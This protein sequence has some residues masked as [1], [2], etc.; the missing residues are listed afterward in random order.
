MFEPP[1][2]TTDFDH[3]ADA[4]TLAGQTAPDPEP[5]TDDGPWESLELQELKLQELRLKARRAE[6]ERRHTAPTVIDST[7]T[8]VAAAEPPEPVWPHQLIEVQDK[9][10][11]VKQPPAAAIRYLGVFGFG[12]HGVTRGDFQDFMHRHVSA[13]SID[14][15]REWTYAGEIDEGFYDQLLKA[16]TT[17]GTGRPTGPSSSS[18][19]SR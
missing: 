6:L 14:D 17:M 11:Q 4:A 1:E 3:D 10:I 15:I 2:G 18:A 8:D 16:L 12:E 19:R 5:D 13:K 9:Q 7:G